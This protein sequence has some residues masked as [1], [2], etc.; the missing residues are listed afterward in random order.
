MDYGDYYWGLN[1][2]Y[3]TDPFPHS[4]LSTREVKGVSKDALAFPLRSGFWAEYFQACWGML[5]SF[6]LHF[7]LQAISPQTRTLAPNP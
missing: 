6:V 1:R 4:L 2:G 7:V 5:G 3:Y